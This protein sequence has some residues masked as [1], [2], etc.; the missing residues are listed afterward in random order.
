M[1]DSDERRS[2]IILGI[3][4]LVS[5]VVAVVAWNKWAPDVKQQPQYLL[6][7]GHLEV[8]PQPPWIPEDVLQAVVRDGKLE[9]LSIMDETLLEKIESAFAVQTWV[10]DVRLIRKRPGPKIEID[11]QYRRPVAVVEVLTEQGMRALQPVDADGVVLPTDFLRDDPAKTR[12]YLRILAGYG[13]PAGPVGTSWGDAGVVGAARICGKL[14]EHWKQLGLYRVTAVPVPGG[15]G[16]AEFELQ[17]ASG[18][19]ILW[20]HTVGQEPPGE[21][22]AATKVKILLQHARNGT[23]NGQV[24]TTLDIRVAQTALRPPSG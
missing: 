22:D 17:T 9:G 3:L 16:E 15:Q 4:T 8:P 24:P 23:L 19:R 11:L 14:Q 13:M 12:E 20:G 2:L 7:A 21:S 18:A 10:A 6:K 5:L 1:A